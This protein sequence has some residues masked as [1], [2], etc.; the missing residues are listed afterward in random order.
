MPR[1][2]EERDTSSSDSVRHRRRREREEA[3]PIWLRALLLIPSIAKAIWSLFK[4]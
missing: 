1:S 3:Q 2:N 4:R